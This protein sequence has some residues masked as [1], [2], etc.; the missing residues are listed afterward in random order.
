M[1]KFMIISTCY[2]DNIEKA[3]LPWVLATSAQ[4][5]GHNPIIFLQGVAVKMATELGVDELP[6]T[7][8]FPSIRELREIFVSEG[9]KIFYCGPCL[10]SYNIDPRNMIECAKPAGTAFL[11]EQSLDA[12][13][14]TY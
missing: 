14:F 7:S 13:V 5:V 9:G 10:G 3:T 2:T 11:V 12:K 1:Q 4:A 8:C 6:Q